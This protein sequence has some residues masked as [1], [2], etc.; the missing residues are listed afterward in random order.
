MHLQLKN[1]YIRLRVFLWVSMLVGFTLCLLQSMGFFFNFDAL[2]FSL[3][4]TL[5]YSFLPLPVMILIIMF[6]TFLPGLA[7]VEEGTIKGFIYTCII[8]FFYIVLIHS[9]ASQSSVYIPMVAPLLGCILSMIRI[10]AWEESLLIQEN[11]GMRKTFGSYVEPRIAD[12]LLNNPDMYHQDGVRTHVTIMFADLRGFTQLCENTAPEVIISMLRDC[13]GRLITIARMHDGTIDKLIGDSMMVVWGNPIPLENHAEKAVAAAIEMQAAML[14]LKEKW[15]EQLGVEIKLG[16]GINTDEVVAGTI[17][18]QE[19]CDYTVLGSGV[20]LASRLES[21]CP[22][23][24]IC[25]SETTRTQV[26]N[27]FNFSEP[28]ILQSKHNTGSISAYQVLA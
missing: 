13:F 23:D 7:I 14:E 25:V 28:A 20:N 15:K 12:M 5:E 11:D 10:L 17:G 21:V 22:G 8:W 1:E 18:S 4:S 6:H 2:L 26:Q 16:I 27:R 19:F 3:D 9:C 24:K